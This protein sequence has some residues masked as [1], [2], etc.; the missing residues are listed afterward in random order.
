MFETTDFKSLYTFLMVS[1]RVARLLRPAEAS[2]W[3]IAARPAVRWEQERESR[4]GGALGGAS[5]FPGRARGPTACSRAWW[6]DRLG[7]KPREQRRLWLGRNTK[8]A[9]SADQ[10]RCFLSD[11]ISQYVH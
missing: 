10:F 9:D 3:V 1:R 4:G 5:A 11:F 7:Q 6:R 8:C 2:L